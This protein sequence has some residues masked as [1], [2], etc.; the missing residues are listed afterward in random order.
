MN[1][2]RK[3]LAA[4]IFVANANANANANA[5]VLIIAIMSVLVALSMRDGFAQYL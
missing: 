2:F 3:S 4:R 5:A 1:R